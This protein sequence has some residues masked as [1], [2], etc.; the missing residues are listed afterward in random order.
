MKEFW[1]TGIALLLAAGLFAFYWFYES[2]QEPKPETES[3]KV[4]LLT[5]DK[6]KAKELKVSVK[7]GDGIDLVKE[8]TFWKL[9]APFAAPA[10][11]SAV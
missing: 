11:T 1:K 10:D 5:V 3:T 9:T 6:A 7:G 2:K 4:T 8:G